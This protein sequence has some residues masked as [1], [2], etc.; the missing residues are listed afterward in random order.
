MKS[1]LKTSNSSRAA[2]L[3]NEPDKRIS[4]CKCVK[5]MRRYTKISCVVCVCVC[6]CV[7]V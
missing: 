6:V 2:F 3:T 5:K 1:I 4:L 7:C